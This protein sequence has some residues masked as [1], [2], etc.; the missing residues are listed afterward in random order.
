M[1]GQPSTYREFWPFYLREHANPR[2]RGLHYLGSTLALAALAAFFVTRAWPF[3]LVAP[4]AGYGFAW[5][6]HFLIEG[7][8]PAT[9]RRPLWSLASD[10]RMLALW[11]SGRLGP[12]LVRAGV[13]PTA[14]RVASPP[15]SD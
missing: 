13:S 14:Q 3:L 2:S 4:I 10:Y 5:L 11:A 12:H 8:R 7:N 15:A 1:T 9:F 6:G